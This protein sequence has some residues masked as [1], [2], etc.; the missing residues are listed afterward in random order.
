MTAPL[1][2]IRVTTVRYS[3][4]YST[5]FLGAAFASAAIGLAAH[6][7]LGELSLFERIEQ[8]FPE[9]PPQLALKFLA[10]LVGLALASSFVEAILAGRIGTGDG[11][12]EP[13]SGGTLQ[14]TL[15]DV[16]ARVEQHMSGTEP[17]VAA[18]MDEILQGALVLNA[19]DVHLNPFSSLLKVTYRV[20]GV[21]HEVVTVADQYG[22]RMTQRVKIL[23]RLEIYSREPQDG[24]LRRKVGDTEV[25]ARVSCL[26]ANHGERIVMRLVRGGEGI[27]SIADLGFE[28]DVALKLEQVLARP[29]GIFYVSGPVG[30]GKTT[31][32]Y[33]ALSHLHA[34]RGETTSLVTLEDPI[35]H[36]LSFATQTQMNVKQGMSFAQTLR[37]VLRQDPGALMVGEIRDRETAEIAT[38]A[39]L[40]GH[41]ILTTIHV[42]SAAG[43]FARLIEMDVEPFILASSSAG[44]LAQRLVRGLCVECRVA[45]APDREVLAQFQRL[46][47]RLPDAQYFEPRGCSACD[48]RGYL[49]RLPIAE[50][51]IMSDALRAAV[52]ERASQEVIHRLAISEGMTPLVWSGLK[53]AMKGD[54]S[55]LEVLRVAG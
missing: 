10:A 20:D 24:S 36:Q 3:R 26:P 31:T 6:L 5:W 17:D 28:K 23:S 15:A 29:Q 44:S 39:G 47:I 13:A 1:L 18:G 30:S 14:Q 22:Q 16:K 8:V 35:E 50:I 42:Q 34:R 19:S 11:R 33:S 2:Q 46:G 32:L 9:G 25:E 51:L 12:I 53:L 37:S 27:P 41:L 45:N 40:T 43:T 48:G 49:G 55:L 38:Q 21:L 7:V 52:H 54:T 4:E